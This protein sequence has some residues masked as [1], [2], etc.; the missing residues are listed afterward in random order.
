MPDILFEKKPHKTRM[1]TVD[2]KIVDITSEWK[3]EDCILVFKT[4]G[5]TF[6]VR[7]LDMISNMMVHSG[8]QEAR[9]M[10]DGL[11]ARS[12]KKEVISYPFKFR[13]TKPH[14]PGELISCEIQ[15]TVPEE[16]RSVKYIERRDIVHEGK[17]GIVSA[18]AGAGQI[19]GGQSINDILSPKG[20]GK[21]GIV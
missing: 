18:P 21:H 16:L 20:G 2:G 17:S 7:G 6:A 12:K 11:M 15:I 10:S 14:L 8:E 9:Y 5:K 13:V 4:Q 19:P 3:G 1:E